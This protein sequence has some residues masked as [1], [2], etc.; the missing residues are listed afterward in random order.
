MT[1]CDT[2]MMTPGGPVLINSG[3]ELQLVAVMAG[4][5]GDQFTL[6]VPTHTKL[7]MLRDRPCP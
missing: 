1:D 3:V 5:F 4:F 6:A 2:T 7:S